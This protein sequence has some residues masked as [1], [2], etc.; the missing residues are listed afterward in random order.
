MK[1]K[2]R[3][4]ITKYSL[5]FFTIFLFLQTAKAQ[6]DIDSGYILLSENDTIY[7]NIVNNNYYINSQY[8]EFQE[9]ETDTW[10]KYYP[11]ELF[12]YR[13]NFGKYYVSETIKIENNDAN[14]FVEFIINGE[15]DMYFYQDNMKRNHYYVSKS[16]SVLNELI[17]SKNYVTID[18]KL[19]EKEEKPYVLLLKT[20]TKSHP[21]FK[22]DIRRLKEPSHKKLI[23]LGEKY[24]KAVCADGLCLI[25]EKKMKYR[26][27]VE[28]V[29]GYKMIFL[30]QERYL[31]TNNPFYGI[32][33]SVN[34]PNFSE[35][36]YFSIGYIHEGIPQDSMN[37]VINNYKI[38]ITYG[39]RST[40]KGLGF[41]FFGGL[42][43][44]SFVITSVSLA[45]GLK[46]D[47][48]KVYIKM[49]SEF[50][51]LSFAVIPAKFYSLNIGFGLA[52][53]L[54]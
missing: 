40:G 23:K 25:Y 33:F 21:E 35:K 44:R 30:D 32:N 19:F 4:G 27:E 38:P 14:L 12:G 46:L 18:G 22:D 6:K 2:L 24:H 45:P 31:Q 42:N 9:N 48:G 41:M 1:L 5:L 53:K 36:S 49:Y 26:F 8:C 28:A 15:L 50:E 13:F 43:L 10:K 52:Y 34:N 37:Y 20:L 39:Y 11:N 54:N 47:L 29:S 17:Y 3:F 51:F 16:D 7:G